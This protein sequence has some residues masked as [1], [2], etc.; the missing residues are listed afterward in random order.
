MFQ[1]LA[2]FLSSITAINWF[3]I[4]SAISLFVH[5]LGVVNAGHAVM[6]VKSSRSAIAW[7]MALISFPW[8]TIPLYW[9]LGK[10]K[11]KGYSEALKIA[12]GEHQDIVRQAYDE[13]LQFKAHLPPEFAALERLADRFTSL[14]F[15]THNTLELLVDGE[16]TYASMLDAIAQA[17]TYILF[18]TYIIHDDDISNQ[19]KDALIAKAQQGVRVYLLYDGLGSRTLPRRYIDALR[20][21]GVAVS[22]FRSSQGRGIRFQL[23]FRNHRKIL[24]VDGETAFTG[25]LNIGD[26]YLGKDPNLGDW[27]DTHTKVVGPAV[28]CLQ[29]TL[30][31]DWYWAERDVPDVDWTIEQRS[32]KPTEAIAQTSPEFTGQT[33]F[34]LATGPADPLQ[35]CSLFFLNLINHAKERLWIASPYFVPDGSTLNA[36]KLA[37]I[38]GV[39]VRLIL[40]HRPDQRLVYFCSFS[41]Y[42]ELQQVGIQV[43]RHQP[44]F[45]H[46]KVILCDAAIAGVGTVNLDNRSFFLNFEV[47]AF[48]VNHTPPVSGHDPSQASETTRFIHSVEKMLQDDLETSR[49]VDLSKYQSKPIWFKLAARVSRLLAPIL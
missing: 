34:I 45:M 41:Y 22:S 2:Q 44:G 31:G 40:P 5:A 9:I 26:E 37:A 6:N 42:E 33:A 14:P 29:R 27:R 21:S 18:Q 28:K 32:E 48:A 10:R 43:Y 17:K 46:Q 47:M 13:I 36:L 3:A 8:V 20:E 4:F 35:S 7:S 15:T 1:G 25:G 24:I 12:Y 39:D 11:F 49:V 23:N 19:F 38:R 16:Q 30:L